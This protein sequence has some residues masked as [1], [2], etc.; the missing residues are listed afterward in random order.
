[1]SQRNHWVRTRSIYTPGTAGFQTIRIRYASSRKS[2]IRQCH[3]QF[4]NVFH[5]TCFSPENLWNTNLLLTVRA[6][7]H[8]RQTRLC[9]RSDNNHPEAVRGNKPRRQPR[10][11]LTLPSRTL[12]TGEGS[13]AARHPSASVSRRN[14]VHLSSP[15]R[16]VFAITSIISSVMPGYTPTQKESRMMR[17]VSLSSPTTRY[18][19]PRARSSEKQG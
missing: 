15:S 4:S 18:P 19:S 2:S 13:S 14:P 8:A 17:S 6:T 16:I 11:W 10:Y 3:T 5:Q 12:Q 7:Q 1:M 9:Y